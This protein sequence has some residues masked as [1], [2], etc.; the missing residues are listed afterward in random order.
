ML[1]L[2]LI[3]VIKK[4]EYTEGVLFDIDANKSICQSLENRV[5]DVNADGDLDDEYEGKV[6]GETAIPYGT[7]KIK[8]T[9]SPAFDKRMVLIK[10]VKHFTG[11]R[12]HWGATALNSEG[13]ILVGRKIADGM[14]GNTGMTDYLVQ[15]LEAH[16]NQGTIEIV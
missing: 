5:R 11:I 15:L 12:L 10:G 16:G 8:V 3:R 2:K 7:Y 9:Y 1:R 14:L 6:Y 4:E 13:C